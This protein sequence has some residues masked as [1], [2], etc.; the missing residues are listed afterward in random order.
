M[1]GEWQ[2]TGPESRTLPPILTVRARLKL[3]DN[4][5]ISLVKGAQ[6]IGRDNLNGIV[7]EDSVTYISRRHLIIRFENGQY[8][9][10][11]QGSTNGT[12][13]N[14]TEIKGKGK[15]ELNNGDLIEVADVVVFSFMTS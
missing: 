6:W 12:R 5:E 15:F 1:L 3:S 7:S 10:E 9:V 4:R 11:D 14:G 13:F 8:Y 2:K